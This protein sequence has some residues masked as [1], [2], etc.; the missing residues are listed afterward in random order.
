VKEKKEKLSSLTNQFVDTIVSDKMKAN[1]LLKELEDASAE[2]QRKKTEREAQQKIAT[3]MASRART[4]AE[5]LAVE[6]EIL[7]RAVDAERERKEREEREEQERQE[8]AKREAE[9]LE[10]ALALEAEKRAQ[11]ERERAAAE[12]AERE[13]ERIVASKL[14]AEKAAKE[15]QEAER[16]VAE[17]RKLEREKTNPSP[18]PNQ[19]LEFG[20]VLK[21]CPN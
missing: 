16:K 4:N 20:E 15:R 9:E 17:T 11:E 1:A 18:A 7:D 8:R 2:K 6:K 14:A 12:R 13:A 10:R 3:E 19:P 21:M 5:K